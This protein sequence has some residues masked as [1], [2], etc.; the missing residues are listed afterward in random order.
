MISNTWYMI[1]NTLYKI[2]YTWHMISNTWY[3]IHDK[4][5]FYH[6]KRFFNL[7][8][9]IYIFR[10]FSIARE[11]KEKKTLYKRQENIV[12]K[13][14]IFITDPQNVSKFNHYGTDK[15]V[16]TSS[17]WSYHLLSPL[18]VHSIKEAIRVGVTTKS[19]KFKTSYTIASRFK[20]S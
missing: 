9:L 5:T 4:K 2:Y 13:F 1:Y 7:I 19:T 3:M 20:G 14:Q 10:S 11:Q 12:L 8:I 6:N 18:F 16:W 15:N 17:V